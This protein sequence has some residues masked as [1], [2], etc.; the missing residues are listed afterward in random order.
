MAWNKFLD[1][2]RVISILKSY[3][4]LDQASGSFI[5]SGTK[6]V[7][8]FSIAKEFAK[9]TNCLNS[10]GDSCSICRNCV[11]IESESH[12]DL[13]IVRPT[14][15]SEEITIDMI[16]DLQKFL[17]LSSVNTDKKFF[18]IDEAEKM[19]IEAANAFL[20]SLEEPPVDSV[21]ILISSRVSAMIPTIRSRCKELKFRPLSRESLE[22]I[23]KDKFELTA[24][25]AKKISAISGGG[26]DFEP[27]NIDLTDMEL[28]LRTFFHSLSFRERGDKTPLHQQRKRLK[29]NIK[30]LILYIRDILCIINKVDALVV[31]VDRYGRDIPLNADSKDLIEKI[32]K[33]EYLYSALD[34]NVNPDFVYKVVRDIYKEVSVKSEIYS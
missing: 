28:R 8:K 21:I 31:S 9:S 22:T 17:N 25:D 19:N 10:P 29:A 7:G 32:E 14:D 16:R 30:S 6:G 1:Q 15:K 33:L 2:D 5:F 13:Y 12:P 24:E 23:L 18:I 26:L 27:G 34:S 11:Q 3:I 4:N 20:K